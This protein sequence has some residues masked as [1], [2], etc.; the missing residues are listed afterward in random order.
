MCKIFWMRIVCISFWL[1]WSTE[2]GLN[3]YVGGQIIFIVVACII[4]TFGAAI[5]SIKSLL[6]C[7]SLLL[8]C[9][10]LCYIHTH[11][12]WIAAYSLRIDWHTHIETENTKRC[13]KKI[14]FIQFI[15]VLERICL[16]AHSLF[17]YNTRFTLE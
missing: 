12:H 1:E 4:I 14:V 2:T 8:C 17:L 6:C 13:W 3:W 11:T 7:I 10:Q 16:E 5:H 15:W 9:Y